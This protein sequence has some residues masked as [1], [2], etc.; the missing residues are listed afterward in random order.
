[1]GIEWCSCGRKFSLLGGAV[2]GTGKNSP[3]REKWPVF[4]D[5]GHAGRVLYRLGFEVGVVGRVLYRLGWWLGG[6]VPVMGIEWCSC[7]RKFS[8]LGGAALETRKSSPCSGKMARFWCFWACWASFFA[9]WPGLGCCWASFFARERL[10]GRAGRT[11]SRGNGWRGVLGE[12]FRG[13]AKI[14]LLLGKLFCAGTVGGAR[15]ANF[16]AR[17]R[18][19]GLAGRTFSRSGVIRPPARAPRGANRQ[20]LADDGLLFRHADD[21]G[22]LAQGQGRGH[23]HGAG[24]AREHEENQHVFGAHGQD[25]GDAGGQADGREC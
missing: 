6:G 17:E 11:F 16:F 15:W 10:E 9:V 25:W 18:L 3:A 8:L 13:L 22:A 21:A 14:G 1:M 12:F 4:V 20:Q 19:D 7:G 5:C 24:A 23:G 2:L